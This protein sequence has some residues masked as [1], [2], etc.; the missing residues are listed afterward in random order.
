MSANAG[1]AYHLRGAAWHLLSLKAFVKRG[2]NAL[3][4]EHKDRPDP[5]V[6]PGARACAL[7]ESSALGLPK[8]DGRLPV[9]DEQ[10]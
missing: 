4:A 6:P 5:Q 8:T 7:P 9:L 10:A 3:S 1:M 2:E